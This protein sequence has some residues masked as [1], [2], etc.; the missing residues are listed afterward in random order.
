[1]QA[2]KKAAAGMVHN[3]INQA[4]QCSITPCRYC[5]NRQPSINPDGRSGEWWQFWACRLFGEFPCRSRKLISLK[6][7]RRTSQATSTGLVVFGASSAGIAKSFRRASS[8]GNYASCKICSMTYEKG[9][10][11]H[12]EIS[13]NHVGSPLERQELYTAVS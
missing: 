12:A 10:G 8:R 5:K 1:M 6:L 11:N 3:P 4:V 7:R 2:Q 13:E 9:D